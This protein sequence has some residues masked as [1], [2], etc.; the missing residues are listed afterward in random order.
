MERFDPSL[1]HHK[2]QQ[3]PDIFGYWS[4]FHEPEIH[5]LSLTGGVVETYVGINYLADA[6][7]M[8]EEISKQ[9]FRYVVSF[10]LALLE[11]NSPEAAPSTFHL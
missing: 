8:L 11:E 1:S 2:Q 5:S 6:A 4:T 3:N 7:E 10:N 9:C